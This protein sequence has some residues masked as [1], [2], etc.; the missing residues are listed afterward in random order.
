[1]GGTPIF[2]NE[3]S[4]D[5]RHSCIAFF[6]AWFWNLFERAQEQE[7]PVS[8]FFVVEN[9]DADV[10]NNDLLKVGSGPLFPNSIWYI[11]SSWSPTSASSAYLE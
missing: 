4:F 1:V 3:L 6:L 9:S 11:K 8:T 5:F 7:T 10:G 2:R